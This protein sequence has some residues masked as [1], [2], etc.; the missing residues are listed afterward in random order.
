MSFRISNDIIV[1]SLKLNGL[2]ADGKF[3]IN[4][5]SDNDIFDYVSLKNPNDITFSNAKISDVADPVDDNDVV[6][7]IY[8]TSYVSGAGASSIT[9][10]GDINIP[11][12]NP[13]VFVNIVS[14]GTGIIPVSTNGATLKIVISQFTAGQTYTL[15]FDGVN[16]TNLISAGGNSTSI[17]FTSLGQGATLIYNLALNAWILESGGATIN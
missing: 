13:V 12:N 8:L 4:P 7:K 16:P 11:V 17:I 1:S 10:N 2:Y 5:G 15:N 14:T 6:T 9:V 3:I